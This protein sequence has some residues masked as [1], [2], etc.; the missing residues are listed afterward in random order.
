VPNAPAARADAPAPSA[1][2]P[3]DRAPAVER[4]H[5]LRDG[6]LASIAGA[7]LGAAASPHDRVR[8]GIIGAVAGGAVGAVYGR[9]DRSWAAYEPPSYRTY[10]GL[11][12]YPSY[13]GL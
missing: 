13:R 4:T 10:T 5:A 12:R 11:R 2:L 7:I 9:G 1:V 8:G 6:V 3:V